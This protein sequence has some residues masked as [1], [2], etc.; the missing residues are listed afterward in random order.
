MIAADVR[1]TNARSGLSAHRYTCTGNAVEGSSGES[2]TSTMNATMP[3][4]RS[5]A[6]SP[7]ALAMPMIVPVS[8]PGIASGSTWCITICIFDAP[9]P[10]AASRIE[11]GTAVNAARDAMMITGSVIKLSTSPPTSGAERG[12][13]NDVDEQRE[14]EQ[15]EHDRRHGSEVVDVHLDQIGPAVA[16]RELL[17]IDRGRDAERER[18]EQRHEQHVERADRRA[19]DARELGIARIAGREEVA[20]ETQPDALLLL[21]LVEPCELAVIDA[22]VGLGHITAHVAFD[23]HVDVVVGDAARR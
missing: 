1:S 18:Q 9:R 6:D 5:G 8:M 4:I 3:I 13:P 21:E 19:P 16:P 23:E 7:S 10:S 15:A 2:G 22:P 17:E 14:T 20:I 11:G 12:N